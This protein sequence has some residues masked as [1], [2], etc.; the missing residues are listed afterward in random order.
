MASPVDGSY[1]P[2]WLT[3]KLDYKNL[4]LTHEEKKKSD[5]N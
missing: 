2:L 5:I 4:V 1:S 3:H